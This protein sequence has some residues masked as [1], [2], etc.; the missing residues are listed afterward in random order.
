MTI[1][2][3]GAFCTS[4]FA[5]DTAASTGSEPDAQQVQIKGQHSGKLPEQ[6]FAAMR[7]AYRLSDGRL[8]F[9]G[10]A[11]Q[12]PT[13]ELGATTA[14]ALQAAG[15]N[16]LVSADGSMVLRFKARANGDIDE[17]IVSLPAAGIQVSSSRF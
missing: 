14:V 2:A 1:G 9:V 17:V 13:A 5:A 12:R 11:R 16:R 15:P 4:V 6:E 10:G 3:V 8:L 7:G